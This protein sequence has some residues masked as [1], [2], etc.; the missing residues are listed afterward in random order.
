MGN[1]TTVGDITEDD[2]TE[3]C[4][5]SNHEDSNKERYIKVSFPKL[6]G[7]DAY[8]SLF[9]LENKYRKRKFILISESDYKMLGFDANRFYIIHDDEMKI[10]SIPING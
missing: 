6:L 1:T 7:K 3:L 8:S 9:S 5:E 4:E 2:L 10:S